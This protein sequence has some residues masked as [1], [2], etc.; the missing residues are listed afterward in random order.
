VADKV[1]EAG[2]VIAGGHTVVDAEPK[3]GLC[4]TDRVHPDR[5]FVKG[6]LRAGDR[7]FLSKPLGTG[8]VTTAAKEGAASGEIVSAAID[9]MLRLNRLAAELA[10][11]S[12]VA[13]ATD[14]TGFGVL[15]HLLE[16]TEAS[17][18]GVTVRAGRL[19]WLPSA[20]DLAEAGHWSAGTNRNRRHVDTVLGPRL[21]ID[22]DVTTGRHIATDRSRD[23]RQVVVRPRSGP[24]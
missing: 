24:R 19:P 16:M 10:R 3:Y 22:P 21:Q 5:L 18:I 7:L 12:G 17:G 2:G 15:G 1:A 8:V 4:V 14:V 23:V 13:A 20:R 9:S 6:R 11:Q